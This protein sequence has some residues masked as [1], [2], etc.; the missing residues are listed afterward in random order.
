MSTHQVFCCPR[1]DGGVLV[2]F[3]EADLSQ[4]LWDLLGDD[5]DDYSL[6]HQN[7]ICD[8]WIHSKFSS[9]GCD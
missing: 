9:S 3:S 6:T 8:F 4:V 1:M 5:H 7:E 2:S